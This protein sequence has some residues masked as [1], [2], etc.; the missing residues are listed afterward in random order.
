[1]VLAEN[2]RFEGS[3]RDSGLK[4]ADCLESLEIYSDGKNTYDISGTPDATIST[5]DGQ[6]FLRSYFERSKKQV[7]STLRLGGTSMTAETYARKT[8]CG[9][10]SLRGADVWVRRKQCHNIIMLGTRNLIMKHR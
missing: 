6:K 1:M 7:L 3:D 4:A 10:T 2:Q 8:Q 9:A 5:H